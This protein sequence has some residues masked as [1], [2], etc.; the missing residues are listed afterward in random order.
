MVAVYINIK[1]SSNQKQY[2]NVKEDVLNHLGKI[3]LC[4]NLIKSVES[5][6]RKMNIYT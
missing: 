2:L 4:K 1:I 5:L 6:P 3:C